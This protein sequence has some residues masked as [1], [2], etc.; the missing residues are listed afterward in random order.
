MFEP[1]PQ[2]KQS[3]TSSSVWIGVIVVVIIAAAVMLFMMI[4]KGPAVPVASAPAAPLAKA[5]PVHDLRVQRAAMDKD[6]SGTTAVWAIAIENRS[7]SYGYHD[8]EYETTYFNADGK[9][10]ASNKGKLS[11][12]LDPQQEKNTEVRDLAYPSGTAT[13]KIRITSAAS[14][15]E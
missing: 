1:P 10:I 4:T 14:Q 2:E 6:T 7:P 5:D 3:S 8:I 11:L 15:V 13:Y 9:V 12:S